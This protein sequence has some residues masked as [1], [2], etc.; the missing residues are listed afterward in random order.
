[1]RIELPQTPS[2]EF[3]LWQKVI[4]LLYTNDT[5]VALEYKDN[6]ATN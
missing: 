6:N 4:Q 3:E 5:T 1:M 2:D